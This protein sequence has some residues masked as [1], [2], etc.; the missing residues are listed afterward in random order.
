[1]LK[2][3]PYIKSWVRI[4][5]NKIFH[6]T[7]ALQVAPV[8]FAVNQDSV[9]LSTTPPYRL[10]IHVSIIQFRSSLSYLL[11]IGIGSTRIPFAADNVLDSLDGQQYFL[12][13]PQLD[14]A[15]VLEILP[16]H[17]GNIAHRLV[18]LFEQRLYVLLQSQQLQPLLNRALQNRWSNSLW[19]DRVSAFIT[20]VYIEKLIAFDLCQPPQL[21][22]HENPSYKLSMN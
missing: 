11:L 16:S 15:N 2:A 22:P 1:M 6:L 18:V 9:C 21:Q 7:S 5:N 8:W 3:K 14:N 20:Y 17:L 10:N 12:L 13:M 4:Q 19:V